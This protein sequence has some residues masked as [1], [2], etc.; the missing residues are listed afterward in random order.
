MK[1]FTHLHQ[2]LDEIGLRLEAWAAGTRPGHSVRA[3]SQGLDGVNARPKSKSLPE[4][5][6]ASAMRS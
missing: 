6:P 1:W 2:Q 4:L 3:E 5:A